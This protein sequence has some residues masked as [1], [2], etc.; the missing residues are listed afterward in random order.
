MMNGITRSAMIKKN[1][2]DEGNNPG[3]LYTHENPGS[4]N[5]RSLVLIRG[6]N[7]GKKTLSVFYVSSKKKL[8]L[9]TPSI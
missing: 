6:F 3:N 8:I 7:C 1:F 4:D 9:L 2:L 5:E